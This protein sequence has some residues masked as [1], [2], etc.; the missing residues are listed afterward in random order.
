MLDYIKLCCRKL[1]R[2]EPSLVA[3]KC[4]LSKAKF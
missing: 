4:D 2:F 3:F 1:E